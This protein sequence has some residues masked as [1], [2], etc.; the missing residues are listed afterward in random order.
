[1]PR[2]R[3]RGEYSNAAAGNWTIVMFNF[4][5]DDGDLLAC[6]HVCFAA[7]RLSCLAGR[8]MV[9]LHIWRNTY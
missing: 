5:I 3:G 1:M 9:Y 6:L 7:V 2:S 4:N 8:L